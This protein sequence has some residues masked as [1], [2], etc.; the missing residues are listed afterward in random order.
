MGIVSMLFVVLKGKSI[1]VFIIYGLNKSKI[2]VS[3]GL[4]FKKEMFVQFD[5]DWKYFGWISKLIR[6]VY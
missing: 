1:K 4:I 2:Y 3:S 6:K 5:E